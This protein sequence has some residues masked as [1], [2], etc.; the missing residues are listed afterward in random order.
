MDEKAKKVLDSLQAQCARREYCTSDILEK[1]IRKMEGDREGAEEIVASLIKDRY[2]EDL[3][4]ASAFA[5]EKAG[6]SGWG[7]V[8]I[9]YALS[10]KRIS[11]ADIDAA[12]DEIDGSKAQEKLLR[13]LE[14]KWKS[15]EGDPQAKLK[16]L[17]FALGRGYEYDDV[18]SI[19]DRMAN[20]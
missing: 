20:G 16:L 15:L 17:K 10:A 1:A 6:I 19:V 3:R 4:Y 11:K 13:L 7:P 8:K 2:V 9:R 18:K 5:R 14:T 12:L